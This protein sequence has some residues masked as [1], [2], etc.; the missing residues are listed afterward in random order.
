MK[1][2]I[3]LATSLVFTLAMCGVGAQFVVAC[4]G[5]DESTSDGG[6]STDASTKDGTVV[7]PDSSVQDSGKS[8]AADGS[9]AKPDSSVPDSGP[10]DSGQGADAGQDA[11]PD[12]SQDAAPDASQDAAIDG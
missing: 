2:N 3:R 12:A 1:Q 9:V 6:A 10:S 5:S 4:S 8:D 11:A 7:N